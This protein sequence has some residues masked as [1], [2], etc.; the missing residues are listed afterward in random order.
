MRWSLHLNQPDLL[1]S[2][3]FGTLPPEQRHAAV[4]RTGTFQRTRGGKG[5][6]RAAVPLILDLCSMQSVLLLYTALLLF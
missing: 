1:C 3:L 2:A 4:P 6:T 5:P